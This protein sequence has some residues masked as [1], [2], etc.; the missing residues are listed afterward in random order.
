MFFG[1]GYRVPTHGVGNIDLMKK[2]LRRRICFEFR[3]GEAFNVEIVDY[4]RG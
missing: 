3:K 1:Y 4:H 2:K